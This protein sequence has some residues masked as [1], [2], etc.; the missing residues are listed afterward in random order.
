[1]TQLKRNQTEGQRQF[2]WRAPVSIVNLAIQQADKEDE[3]LN[4]IVTKAVELYCKLR[5]DVELVKE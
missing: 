4:A 2:S 1:M 3:S 5:N